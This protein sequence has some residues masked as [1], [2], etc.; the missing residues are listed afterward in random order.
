MAVVLD[1]AV[2]VQGLVE[3]PELAVVQ[4]EVP[5]LAVVGAVGAAVGSTINSLA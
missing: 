1:Q 5:G 4:V 3:V 2:V